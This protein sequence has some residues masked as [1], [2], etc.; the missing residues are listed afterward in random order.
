MDDPLAARP[1]VL[2]PQNPGDAAKLRVLLDDPAV[3]VHDT[4][5]Q[6]LADLLETREPATTFSAGAIADRVEAAI[7]G[8]DT[9]QLGVWVHYPWS[10]RLVHLL[11]QPDFVELR[12]SRNRHKITEPE[13]ETLATKRVGVVGLSVG[14]SVALTLALERSAGELRLADPD[15]IDLSNLN[16]LRAGVHEIGVSKVR[17]TAREI[18]EIDPF[19]PLRGFEDGLT[20][21]N[22]DA[23]LC[24]GGKLDLVVDECD[25]L[26]MKF[27][28]RMRARELGI[29]V[30][31]DTSDRG[32]LDVERFDLEPGR[33]MFHGRVDEIEPARLRSLTDKERV[34]IVADIVGRGTMS[35]RA[36]ASILEIGET[37]RTWP[38]LA[39]AVS[40]GG[41]IAGDTIRR[42]LLHEPVASGRYFV[43]L[44]GAI[45]EATV[46]HRDGAVRSTP[47]RAAAAQHKTEPGGILED[48]V[49]AA[50]Q[51]P[52]GGNCQ[53]WRFLG[54]DDG[55]WV[56]H[57]RE[58]SR[59]FLDF[60]DTAAM[61]ALGAATENLVLAAHA[62]GR[63]VSV[64]PFPA[65]A[66]ASPCVARVE[67]G[68]E[69][70]ESHSFDA[71]GALIDRRHTNRRLGAREPL[72]RG[73]A[74]ALATGAGSIPGCRLLLLD[75][76]EELDEIG[77]I[78]GRGDRLRFLN[79]RLHGEMMA[80]LRWNPEEAR[81]TRDGI[82]VATLELSGADRAGLEICRSWQ[83]MKVLRHLGQGFALAK[84]ARKAVAA[85]SAV[86]LVVV[87]GTT[88]K[89]F[90]QGGRAMQRV[91]LTAENEGLAVQPLSALPYLFARH[92]RG[93][94]KE[95]L[96]VQ[97]AE[98]HELR[99]RYE[100]LFDVSSSMGEVLLM[101]FAVAEPATVRALRRPVSEVLERLVGPG[102]RR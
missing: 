77:D 57:D 33:P 59:S 13:Q 82:D 68:G 49:A 8:R 78:L 90:F 26:S 43:D 83:V 76:G 53:P 64:D 44:E 61:A 74:H 27:A 73:V 63:R 94:G 37:V 14:Q 29:P 102:E 93:D 65:D 50:V 89:H 47:D 19:L 52:S 72:G 95:P 79:Q 56:L 4:Y 39:S 51:A 60:E 100:R 6:Q 34:P 11:A 40:L 15:E 98:L 10:R 67:L 66:P 70:A 3:D 32:L 41:G 22:L 16:R 85:A 88:A 46:H 36:A 38:Q 97:R 62:S 9:R 12:T 75:Q 99:A 18:A 24:D 2:D 31:M 69:D 91:W 7:G 21:D 54:G 35:S 87:D 101:R 58:R 96:E 84:A 92:L 1:R 5:V 55:I 48:L 86:G 25:D 23:F 80:E 30:V 20:E 81:A 45:S 42:I 71:L 17:V 28:L